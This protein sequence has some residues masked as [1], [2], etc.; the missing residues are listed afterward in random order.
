MGMEP[1]KGATGGVLSKLGSK[2]IKN[3]SA[4]TWNGINY[5]Y[6]FFFSNYY[7]LSTLHALRRRNSCLENIFLLKDYISPLPCS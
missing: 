5:G 4:Q 7:L 6:F 1:W 2:G 3:M